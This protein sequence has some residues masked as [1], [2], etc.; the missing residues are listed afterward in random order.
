[1]GQFARSIREKTGVRSPCTRRRLKEF[2][3]NEDKDSLLRF[4][5]CSDSRFGRRRNVVLLIEPALAR[6]HRPAYVE[7]VE[8]CS[9]TRRRRAEASLLRQR[10]PPNFVAVGR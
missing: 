10:R 4:P 8:R 1:M 5:S 6:N 3:V 7:P 2:P 9:R